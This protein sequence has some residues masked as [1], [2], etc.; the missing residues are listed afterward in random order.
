MVEKRMPTVYIDKQ[1]PSAQS[2]KKN[3]FR[4][5]NNIQVS[6]A[7]FPTYFFPKYFHGT[8]SQCFFLGLAF[9]LI[10]NATNVQE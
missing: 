9:A 6:L 5:L 4:K 3:F 7:L 2:V 8:N 10:T 1:K